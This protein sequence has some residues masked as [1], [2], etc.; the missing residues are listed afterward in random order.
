MAK[1]FKKIVE[2]AH[3]LVESGIFILSSGREFITIKYR[4]IS[5]NFPK[6]MRLV[7][8]YCLYAV[9]ILLITFVSNNNDFS[10]LTKKGWWRFQRWTF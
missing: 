5:L 4:N 8:S 7:S 9:C 1:Y 10:I 2:N 3:I 6:E